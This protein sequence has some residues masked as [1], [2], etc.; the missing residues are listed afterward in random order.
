MPCSF[1]KSHKPLL[2]NIYRRLSTPSPPNL[3]GDRDIEYSWIA[4]HIPA[5]K[6]NAL[7]FG[8]GDGYMGLLAAM[9]GYT[10]TAV[11]LLPVTWYYNHENLSFV[12]GDILDLDLP[13]NHYDLIINCSTIEHV[14]ISGRYGSKNNSNNGDLEA[15]ATLRRISK[16]GGKLLMSI[17]VGKDRV[18]PP[19]H[20][21]Y[22][23]NRLPLL[24]QGWEIIS[25]EFW[26]KNKDNLWVKTKK[27]RAM[28]IAPSKH[29][30]GLGLYVLESSIFN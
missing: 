8:A 12:R 29:Y 14:G 6:G 26:V 20:R 17:P 7:D 24:L 23:N 21:V 9:R 15:I 4:A 10:V 22:G 28:A 30:Y 5:G 18:F 19:Y 25:E 13:S 1:L 16:P 11:D 27:G 2:R 3:L